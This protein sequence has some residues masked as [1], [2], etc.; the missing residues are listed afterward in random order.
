MHRLSIDSTA[1]KMYLQ[2]HMNIPKPHVEVGISLIS[3]FH[4]FM[5]P[6]GRRRVLELLLANGLKVQLLPTRKMD[7]KTLSSFYGL[8]ISWEHGW[9]TKTLLERLR[10]GELKGGLINYLVFGRQI[11]C[12]CRETTLADYTGARVLE[13]LG[14]GQQSMTDRFAHELQPSTEAP[15]IESFLGK[16]VVIDTHHLR[17]FSG[18]SKGESALRE[19][20]ALLEHEETSFPMFHLQTRNRETFD[21]IRKGKQCFETKIVKEARRIRNFKGP[22]ILEVPP[23]FLSLRDL[24]NTLKELKGRMEDLVA[25]P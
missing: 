14:P 3:L 16:H 5:L 1:Q 18:C 25:G 20:R 11:K 8:A 2:K 13:V 12:F 21:D 24:K 23:L 15:T 6:D 17:E 19:V 4:I 10:E 7:Q 9:S 22:I